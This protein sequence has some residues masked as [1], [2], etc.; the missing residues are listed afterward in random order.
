MGD[1]PRSSGQGW[2][3]NALDYSLDRYEF[4]GVMGNEADS[5]Q[6]SLNTAFMASSAILSAR[7]I[8][9]IG[10]RRAAILGMLFFGTG[11]ILSGFTVDNVGGLFVTA[12]ALT[13]VG[14]SL[15]FNVVGSLPTQYF[16]RKRGLAN[17]IVFA[18]GGLGGAVLSFAIDALLRGLGTAWTFRVLGFAALITG[19][20]AAWLAKDRVLPNRPSF[21]DWQL[22]KDFRF[23]VLLIAGA[24]GT[25]PLFVP[26]FFLPLYCSSLGLSSSTGAALVAAFNFSSAIGRISCGVL[27]DTIG[28]L[29]TLT[30]SLALTGMSMLVLWPFSVT[31]AP[32]IIFSIINGLATGG[33][34]ALMPTIA[35]RLFGSARVGVAFSMLVTSWSAG[36]LLVSQTV[37]PPSTLANMETGFTYSRI[38]A[39]SIRRTER[40]LRSIQTC[41]VS[42]WIAV[43]VRYCYGR[44]DEVSNWFEDNE[45]TLSRFLC[46]NG[47][48]RKF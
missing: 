43:S 42:C 14:S 11:Q 19:T 30:V 47:C 23:V 16:N 22:L 24:I 15:S 46:E 44:K 12:G 34:F 1:Y 45:E 37:R 38:P 6:G 48:S 21:I 13:G 18:C 28:A 31:L 26:P 3:V 25:F 41:Y 4:D 2:S 36:Y 39:C 32:L 35:G 8:N 40:W 17:G 27:A 9:T 10:T 5:L 29:N 33:Y 20:P 7:L